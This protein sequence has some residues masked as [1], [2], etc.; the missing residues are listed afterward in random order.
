MTYLAADPWIDP[1]R[2]LWDGSRTHFQAGYGNKASGSVGYSSFAFGINAWSQGNDSFAFGNA[3]HSAGMGS[4]AFGNSATANNNYSFAFGNQVSTSGNHSFVFGDSSTS[5]GGVVL[6]NQS[7]A[8]MNAFSSGIQ[9][10][11]GGNGSIAMGY[12]NNVYS[13]HATAIGSH[14]TV[15][16]TG[17]IALGQLN[18]IFFDEIMVGD[19]SGFAI[20]SGLNVGHAD[21]LAVGRF[22]VR[23][24]SWNDG[25][26]FVVGNG[27]SGSSRSD[28]FSVDVNGNV[29]AS[30]TITATGGIS[31]G[32]IH[33]NATG[34]IGIGTTI[35]STKMEV[36]GGSSGVEN[37][38][39]QIRS[40]GTATGTTSTLRFVNS[41]N[42]TSN[43]GA[44]EIA[45]VRV[46]SSAS[47]LV[48]RVSQGSTMTEAMRILNNGNV[49]IG[50]ASPS[51][52][53]HVAGATRAESF[54]IAKPGDSTRRIALGFDP[55]E[56]GEIRFDSASTSG[57]VVAKRSW[58]MDNYNGILRVFSG[59]ASGVTSPPIL[60][61]YSIKARDADPSTSELLMEAKVVKL[62]HP[63]G[64][65]PMGQFTAQN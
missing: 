59:G 17:S 8:A 19:G 20:G 49:G 9:N 7:Y 51:E 15:S 25:Y 6:G 46:A 33:Q 56:G 63:Q 36:V 26:L 31:G 58:N 30:G 12:G 32:S 11:A 42:G 53:L 34:N 45:A 2:L 1:P 64:D 28:A 3:A 23:A 52:K 13:F 40:E 16:G 65:I 35:P 10:W 62:L 54:Y 14:N 43:F 38:L 4:F 22:N 24:G 48:F 61:G 27:T 39:F 5:Y 21:A 47:N 50:T 41:T 55:N 18:Q 37:Q 29:W 44:A 60:S 57:S